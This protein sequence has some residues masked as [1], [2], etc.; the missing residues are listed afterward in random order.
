MQ[1]ARNAVTLA[2]VLSSL[3]VVIAIC[4]LG[5]PGG[6]SAQSTF[7]VTVDSFQNYTVNG[8]PDPTLTLTRGQ[9]YQFV[10]NS[11]G[12]PFYIKTAAVTGTG[13][14]YDTGV[15]G[16]GATSGTITFTVP[17]SAPNQLFYQCSVHSAMSGVINVVNAAAANPVPGVG[18]GAT[19]LTAAGLVALAWFF[20]GRRGWTYASRRS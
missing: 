6:A 4:V 10:V 17:V 13:S 5:A 7:T 19:L 20:M 1:R 14:T 11:P 16:N 3:A 15:T 8:A 18:P 12:H 2:N 9:T